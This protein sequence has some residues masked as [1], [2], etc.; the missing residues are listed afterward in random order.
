MPDLIITTGTVL[1]V[2]MPVRV[3]L[4]WPEKL[5]TRKLL[6][7]FEYA[8]DTDIA[9]SAGE[10]LSTFVREYELRNRTG[11]WA[12]SETILNVYQR[13]IHGIDGQYDM[14]FLGSVTPMGVSVPVEFEDLERAG[15]HPDELADMESEEFMRRMGIED[16]YIP[17]RGASCCIVGIALN[18]E[19]GSRWEP[20][21]YEAYWKASLD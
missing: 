20:F 18:F 4:D 11:F 15:I 16:P 8:P 10:Y 2:G 13:R 12:L 7:E 17:G 6:G 21:N 5:G 1:Q 9:W 19:G 3:E 14:L